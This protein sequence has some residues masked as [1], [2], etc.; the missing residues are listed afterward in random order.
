MQN[1]RI[2][3]LQQGGGWIKAQALRTV[4][5]NVRVLGPAYGAELQICCATCSALLSAITLLSASISGAVC[6]VPPT[7]QPLIDYQSYICA[8]PIDDQTYTC[9]VPIDDW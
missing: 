1:S 4:A 9:A 6:A 3:G 5:M 8:V 7:P 2:Q